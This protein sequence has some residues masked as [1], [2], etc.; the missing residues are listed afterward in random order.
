VAVLAPC[1]WGGAGSTAVAAAIAVWSDKAAAGGVFD[2]WVQQLP[3]GVE[4]GRIPS[5]EDADAWTRRNTLE[6]IQQFPGRVAELQACLVSAVATRVSW[7]FPFEV[8]DA[9]ELRRSL[10]P[11]RRGKSLSIALKLRK[12]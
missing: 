12:T 9:V 8:V 4:I 1:A 5:Q 3:E 6:L 10:R 2:E 11:A 7:R